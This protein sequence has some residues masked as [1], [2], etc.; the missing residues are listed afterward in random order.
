VKEF[1]K[2]WRRKAGCVTLA[3]ACLLLAGWVR[4]EYRIDALSL[5]CSSFTGIG[6]RSI[7]AKIGFT[8][9]TSDEAS[10]SQERLLSWV[11]GYPSGIN[12]GIPNAEGD[13]FGDVDVQHRQEWLGFIFAAGQFKQNI[14][15]TERFATVLIPYWSIVIPLILLSAWL[16]LSKPRVVKPKQTREPA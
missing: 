3:I 4:S 9:F 15:P 12:N 10:Y 13:F 11:S 7:L 1:F 16:L 6:S 8:L 14:S 5:C 2:E